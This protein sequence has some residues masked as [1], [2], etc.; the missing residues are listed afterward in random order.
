MTNN[1]LG[2]PIVGCFNFTGNCNVSNGCEKVFLC[3][4]GDPCTID[5]C[6]S[7]GTCSHAP[8][9][10]SVGGNL[11]S[12]NVCVNGVCDNNSPKNCSDGDMCAKFTCNL[13]V[14][15]VKTPFTAKDCDDHN[16]C[17]NDTCVSSQGCVHINATCGTGDLCTNITCNP[18]KGCQGN[19]KVCPTSDRCKIGKCS[20][21]TCSTT[22]QQL[23]LQTP[24]IVG[25]TLGAGAIAGIA[26][27]AIV[28]AVLLGAAAYKGAQVYNARADL[29]AAGNSNPLYETGGSY[30][31]NKLY[32]DYDAFNK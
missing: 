24:A 26:I 9:N 8:K 29:D 15:C 10:C 14:G 23:C 3:D 27:A 31:E 28:A 22:T 16:A 2:R 12:N 20:N 25:I 30:G 17:T 7:N 1:C 19:P 11:C 32:G 4:D 6:Q 5:T 21:G 13:T 18:I